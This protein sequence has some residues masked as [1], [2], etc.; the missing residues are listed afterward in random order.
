MKKGLTAEAYFWRKKLY[1]LGVFLSKVSPQ[2]ALLPIAQ[3]RFHVT[4]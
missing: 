3:R 2:V 1:R 4:D